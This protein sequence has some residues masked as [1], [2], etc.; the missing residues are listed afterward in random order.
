MDLIFSC[1]GLPP[2]TPAICIA[3][4]WILP[5]NVTRINATAG[6]PISVNGSL[7][8]PP[9]AVIIVT[10]TSNTSSSPVVI[11]VNGTANIDGTLTIVLTDVPAVDTLIP[12]LGA[13]GINGSFNTIEVKSP[14]SCVSLSA[15]E[16][17]DASRSSLSALVSVDNSG[18]KKKKGLSGAAIAGIILGVLI[19]F[20]I[21]GIVG[22]YLLMKHCRAAKP[23]FRKARTRAQTYSTNTTDV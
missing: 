17:Y 15:T 21:V 13:T 2:S 22:G 6:Q 9:T 11:T 14:P 12:L 3:G 20:V 19:L 8:L 23:L 1:R 5:A 4:V 7:D 10:T 16:V 18:C